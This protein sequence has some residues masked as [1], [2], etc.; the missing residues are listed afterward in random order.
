MTRKSD[1][2]IVSLRRFTASAASTMREQR[3][4]DMLMYRDV[5]AADPAAGSSLNR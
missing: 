5:H 1:E 3:L 2:S 4:V